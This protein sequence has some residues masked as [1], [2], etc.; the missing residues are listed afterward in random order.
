MSALAL[1][2]FAGSSPIAR[3]GVVLAG[4]WLLAASSWISVPMV[5]VPMTMQTFAV[6]LIGA[7][8]G[9]RLAAETVAAYLLQGALGAPVFAGGAGGVAHLF[10][11]TGGYLLAFLPAAVLT[12]A[13]S[14]RA[15]GRT[16]LGAC[17]LGL[18]GHAVIFAGG[19]AQLQMFMGLE[20]AVASGV[21]PFLIGTLVKT[22][23]FAAA[24]R[25]L[26]RS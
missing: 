26:A 20:G 21:T 14:E 2:T 22:A 4:S 12:G 7:V 18:L 11:P 3:L 5:P 16:L 13:L 1:R 6:L 23:L 24:W 17:A 10:G 15:F 9:P 19:V 25:L 8:A